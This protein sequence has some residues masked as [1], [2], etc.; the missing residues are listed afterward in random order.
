MSVAPKLLFG[1]LFNVSAW[2]STHQV[3]QDSRKVISINL[4][5]LLREHKRRRKRPNFEVK[6]ITSQGGYLPGS[7]IKAALL[8]VQL[9]Q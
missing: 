8:H 4:N 2:D 6:P 5:F 7:L 9:S 3:I 1:A